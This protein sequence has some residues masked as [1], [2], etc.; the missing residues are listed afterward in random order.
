MSENGI[1]IMCEMRDCENLASYKISDKAIPFHTWRKT[2]WRHV[3]NECNPGFINWQN[4]RKG[5]IFVALLLGWLL[6]GFLPFLLFIF[7]GRL[8]LTF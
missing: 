4:N 2:V 6:A 1:K 8:V 7:L 3:C 5:N